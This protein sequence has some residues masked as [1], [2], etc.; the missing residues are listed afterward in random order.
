[1]SDTIAELFARVGSPL[2]WKLSEDEPGLILDAI[3]CEAV[4]VDPLDVM[5]AKE[6]S[7]VAEVVCNA[8]NA[9]AE[10]AIPH[11][12]KCNEQDRKA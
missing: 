1:M 11:E 6:A 4:N 10:R 5:T 12:G 2:P 7:D 3:H 9:Y 8:V